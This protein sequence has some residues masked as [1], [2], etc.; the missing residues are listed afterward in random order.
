MGFWWLI[1]V[2]GK[3]KTKKHSLAK[4]VEL[5]H[6]LTVTVNMASGKT[7]CAL[8]PNWEKYELIK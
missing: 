2:F 6:Q 1:F 5:N 8:F 3:I 7:H 4:S